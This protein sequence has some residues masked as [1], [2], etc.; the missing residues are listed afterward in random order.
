MGP[1]PKGAT[2]I[3]K[4]FFGWVYARN[5]RGKWHIYKDD[6]WIEAFSQNIEVKPI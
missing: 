4:T 1:K 5:V 3:S 2:H 6:A